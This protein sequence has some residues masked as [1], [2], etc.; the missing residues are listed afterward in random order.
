MTPPHA[1]RGPLPCRLG[2][3]RR[4][5]H[6]L[7]QILLIAVRQSACHS[8]DRLAPAVQHQPPQVTV[9]L[10]ALVPARHGREHI[11]HEPG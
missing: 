1:K 8:G 5:V 2:I 6:E 10:G 7:L 9:T 3:P 4:L 11:R